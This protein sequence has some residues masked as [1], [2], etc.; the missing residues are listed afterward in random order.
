MGFFDKLFKNN[1]NDEDNK[2]ILFAALGSLLSIS[3]GKAT[4]EEGLWIAQ[5]VASINGMTAERHKKI[6]N[7][8]IGDGANAMKNSKKLNENEKIELLDFLIGVAIADGYFHGQEAAF[9]FTYSMFLGFSK[10]KSLNLLNHFFDEYEIDLNEF[11]NA[12][13]QMK[14]RFNEF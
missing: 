9:I 7:R 5:Y 2:Y 1:S 3:D 10:E 11:K 4:S 14:D 13:E 6:L 8:S 12:C